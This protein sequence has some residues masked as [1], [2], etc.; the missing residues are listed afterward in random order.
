MTISEY[1]NRKVPEYTDTMFMDNYTPQTI[2]AAAHS[3][4]IDRY[5]EDA[6][7]E[8]VKVFYEGNVK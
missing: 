8:T 6:S 3:K 4:M 5:T 7:E 1:Q 2:L